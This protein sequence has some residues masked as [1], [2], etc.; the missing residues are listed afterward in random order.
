MNNIVWGEVKSITSSMRKL[1][2]M[3]N[4][5]FRII[6]CIFF[7]LFTF[8]LLIGDIHAFNLDIKNDKITLHADNV[9]LKEILRKIADN[10]IDVYIDPEINPIISASF[11]NS[12][13]EKGLKSILKSLNHIFVWESVSDPLKS[14]SSKRL[15]LAEIQVFRQGKKDLMIPLKIEKPA[16][17][18]FRDQEAEAFS[19]RETKI[20]IRGNLIFVPV[21]LG[22]QGREIETTL[23]LDTGSSS[24]VLHEN[25]ANILEISAY[26]HSK[27]KGVGGIEIETRVTKLDYVRVGPHNKTNLIA[28]IIEYQGQKN[29]QFNGLLGMNFLKDLKYSIDFDRQV[30]SWQQ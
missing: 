25:I 20:T 2:N 23:I 16:I 19:K 6:L 9:P 3:H 30:L 27:A 18:S 17:G 26:S 8:L 11:E 4:I 24:I 28:H 22:Y 13:I 12:D 7:S 15:K 21:T 1:S 10:G 14:A 29:K 5:P